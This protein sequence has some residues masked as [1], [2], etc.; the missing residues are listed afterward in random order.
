MSLTPQTLGYG[1]T[2][3]GAFYAYTNNPVQFYVDPVFTTNT[4]TTITYESYVDSIMSSHSSAGY[5]SNGVV[6]RYYDGLETLSASTFPQYSTY[7]SGCCD[8]KLY[9][10]KSNTSLLLGTVIYIPPVNFC[11]TVIEGPTL[12]TSYDTLND[13]NGFGILSPD[14]DCD[15]MECEPCPLP[16]PDCTCYT[17]S[18]PV[19]APSTFGAYEGC[20][21]GSNS[22]AILSGETVNICAKT[23]TVFP[24][25]PAVITPNGKCLSSSGCTCE[26]EPGLTINDCDPITLLPMGITCSVVNPTEA[27]PNSGQLSLLIT[28]G[29][30]PYTVVWTLENGATI[31]GDTLLNMPEGSYYVKVTDVYNDFSAETTCVLAIDRDCTFDGSVIEFILP[32]P[33]PG[34]TSTPVPTPAPTVCITRPPTPT[35]SA[36]PTP[37]PT[38]ILCSIDVNF[39]KTGLANTYGAVYDVSTSPPTSLF[40]WTSASSTTSTTVQAPIGSVLQVSAFAT[41]GG[42]CSNSSIA[43]TLTDNGVDTNYYWTSAT[44]PPVG[45]INQNITDCNNNYSIAI[46]VGCV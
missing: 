35:P 43:V 33:T 2:I 9:K 38:P 46:Q 41:A 8:N 13:D 25:V 7:L 15:A 26:A 14:D 21:G 23:G 3:E 19:S 40:S 17:I 28:G 18:V 45:G 10:L 31:T 24:L 6:V 36:S 42:G 34:P 22:F 37:T 27:N 1:L 30:N 20:F 16:P 11:Y 39:T 12:P 5:Y 29:T 44:L 32:T 4:A